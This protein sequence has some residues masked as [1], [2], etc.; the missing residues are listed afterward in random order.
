MDFQPLR[1]G[2]RTPLDAGVR[3][4][5]FLSTGGRGF[6]PAGGIDGTIVFPGGVF[7]VDR[8]RS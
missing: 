6:R 1:D 3:R 5:F 4:F 8:L 7:I 2:Q